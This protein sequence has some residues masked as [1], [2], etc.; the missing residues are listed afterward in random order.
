M[1]DDK[2]MSDEDTS[3]S[4]WQNDMVRLWGVRV[5]ALFAAFLLGFVPMW[6][7]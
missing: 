7:V 1:T 3:K 2:K 4:I 5:L 6:R